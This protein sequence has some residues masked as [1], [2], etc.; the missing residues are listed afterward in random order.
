MPVKVRQTPA[1]VVT[2]E[3][4]RSW[5]GSIEWE[6][7]LSMGK[8]AFKIP[9]MHL[10]FVSF[11]RRFLKPGLVSGECKLLLSLI[12]NFISTSWN[13]RH[14]LPRKKLTVR[15]KK[16]PVGQACAMKRRVEEGRH[17]PGFSP[18]LLVGG[19][20]LKHAGRGGD[21]LGLPLQK[22]PSVEARGPFSLWRPGTSTELSRDGGG[23]H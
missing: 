6:M 16:P 2:A 19:R 10:L 4:D 22:S 11:L 20:S 8:M 18:L 3:P 7:S 1:R 13:N 23:Q 21:G 12:R 14:F 5:A 17:S 15:Q 9:K